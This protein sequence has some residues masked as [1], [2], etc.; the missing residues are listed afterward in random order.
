MSRHFPGTR[1][2]HLPV[3]G[4]VAMLVLTFVSS[5][6]KPAATTQPIDTIPLDE[7]AANL[8]DSTATHPVLLHIGFEP[9]FRT[10]HIPGSRYVGPGNDAAGL[11]HLKAAL[12]S[13]PAD[14]P[15]VLYCGCCPWTDCPNVHPA[16]AAA[17]ETGHPSVRVL[18]ITG[19]FE[20]D[21]VAKGLPAVPGAE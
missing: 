17:K 14:Q 6:S 1:P 2:A 20:R 9:L 16:F 3:W 18:Y 11:A 15:V 19:N 12:Q 7:L 21:W 5:C 8:A 4:I 13:I 10:S